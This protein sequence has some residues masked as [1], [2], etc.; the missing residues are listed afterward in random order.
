[1]T[2][3]WPFG[4]VPLGQL[5]GISLLSTEM[6]RTWGKG[7]QIRGPV[8]ALMMTVAGRGALLNR[9]DGPGLSLLRQRLN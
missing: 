6:D 5:R 1:L 8:A 3:P 2:G 9:L 7:A 4:F